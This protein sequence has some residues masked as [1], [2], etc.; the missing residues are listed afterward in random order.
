MGRQSSG[1][2][3][4]PG[5]MTF[6]YPIEFCL[7]ELGTQ[8]FPIYLLYYASRVTFMTMSLLKHFLHIWAL[9]LGSNTPNTVFNNLHLN[10]TNL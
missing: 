9:D 4:S 3:H 5:N 8:P 6:G 1:I 7:G 10:V 2:F